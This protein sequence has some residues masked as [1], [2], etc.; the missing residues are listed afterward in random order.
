M[1]FRRLQGGRLSWAVLAAFSIWL[2]FPNDFWSLPPAVLLWPL[3]LL[4][5]GLEARDWK[6]AF[7]LGWLA[8]GCGMEASLYW[9]CMPIAQVG[10]L[11]W[12]LAPLVS[13]C[14]PAILALQGGMFSALVQAERLRPYFQLAL[15]ASLAWYLLEFAFAWSVGFPWLPLAGALAQWPAL[16]QAAAFCGSYFT[17]AIWLF[18]FLCI[19]A[20]ALA[21]PP[22]GRRMGM[23]CLGFCLAGLL[24][25]HGLSG[26]REPQKTAEYALIVEGNIDQ[27]QKWTPPFQ[28]QSLDVYL[29]LT[30]Q[31]LALAR[32]EGI[33]NPLLIWPETA[34]PFFYEASPLLSAQIA[35]AARRWGCPLLFGAPGLNRE[36]GDAVY[37]RAFLLG[38]AGQTLGIYDKVHLVPFGEY[39]PWWLRVEFLEALLQ[40]VGIYQEGESSTSLDYGNLALGVLI[41]YE[42]IFPWLARDRVE[43]GANIL[44]DISNDGWFGRTPAARQHLYLTALRCVEQNRWLWRATNT[45]ISAVVDNRSRIIE[46]GP[47]F[48]EGSMLWQARLESGRSVY[49]YLGV[50]LPWLA[51][52]ALA[53]L[54]ALGRRRRFG[55]R[56]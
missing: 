45:G 9:L 43:G 33:Q 14:I 30:E 10:G 54:L 36:A 12:A 13:L 44:V 6:A 1:A 50:W 26:G 23:A 55:S 32:E 3:A 31:G 39:L 35:E 15:L 41:C 4:A 7:F 28:K 22:A 24:L 8:T 11:P 52:A 51:C 27:N 40:G 49:Y 25:W 47:Q 21:G 18:A 53:G 38:P 56:I 42:A 16:I 34:M 20:P 2:A 5:I 29:R 17:G 37:N 46:T 48:Q 19:L